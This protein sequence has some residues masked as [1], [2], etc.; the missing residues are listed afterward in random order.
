MT[1]I[2]F[3]YVIAEIKSKDIEVFPENI[4]KIIY[5]FGSEALLQD[6]ENYSEFA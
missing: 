1:N 2:I 6:S 5:I 4:H 3:D